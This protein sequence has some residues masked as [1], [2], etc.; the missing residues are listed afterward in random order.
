METELQ[1]AGWEWAEQEL[2][3][4][5][6]MECELKRNR[7]R[8]ETMNLDDI[9]TSAGNYL[10]AADL[11]RDVVV[12]IS[13]FDSTEF[14][15]DDGYK[16]NKLVLSF[17]G[18]DKSLVLNKTNAAT[19]GEMLGKNVDAWVGQQITIGP[20]K[21]QFGGRLV[22]CIRVR[23][24]RPEAAPAPQQAAP[25]PAPQPAAVGGVPND[26]DQEIPFAPFMKGHEYAV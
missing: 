13:G 10:K 18:K 11:P 4:R 9:Y 22:D 15:E 17:A 25:Q 21:T 6:A 12:T 2:A 7:N 20:D 24:Q 1:P 8:N 16:H 19:I 5:H 23:Y 26:F 14:S 3:Q